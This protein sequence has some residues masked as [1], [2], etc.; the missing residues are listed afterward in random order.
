MIDENQQTKVNSSKDCN[1]CLI[2]ERISMNIQ[3]FCN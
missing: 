3:I 1:E 2:Y